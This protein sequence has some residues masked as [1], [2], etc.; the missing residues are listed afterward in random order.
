M[1]GIELE[2]RGTD[3]RYNFSCCDFKD[4]ICYSGVK[5]ASTIDCGAFG[6]IIS[7]PRRKEINDDR[8]LFKCC[9]LVHSTWRGRMRCVENATHFVDSNASL[10]DTLTR[11]PI[12]CPA[13]FGLSM[14][15]LNGKAAEMKLQ[16]IFRC[17]HVAY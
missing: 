15:K 7:F 12:Q 8:Y 4:A 2:K 5:L 6:F 1:T 3:I 11:I 10:I 17:C 16:V 13:G 14:L 9:E